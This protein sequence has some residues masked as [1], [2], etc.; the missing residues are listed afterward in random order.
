MRASARARSGAGPKAPPIP[1]NRSRHMGLKVLQQ[2]DGASISAAELESVVD[3]VAGHINGAEEGFKLG[4]WPALRPADVPN[5]VAL[6]ALALRRSS[7]T[8]SP[9]VSDGMR[10][11]WASLRAKLT[12]ELGKLDPDDDQRMTISAVQPLA[13]AV[14]R[15]HTFR[16]QSA[17]LSEAAAELEPS[18]APGPGSQQGANRPRPARRSR[19]SLQA[20]ADA[21][22]ETRQ[23]ICFFSTVL[24]VDDD[25]GEEGIVT[26]TNDT[27]LQALGLE[28]EESGVLDA[29][30]RLLLL[31]A[32]C[33]G[34]QDEAARQLFMMADPLARLDCFTDP[35]WLRSQARMLLSS[36]CLS[37]LLASHVVGLC[38]ALDGGPTYGMPGPAA[39][40]QDDEEQ[41]GGAA[42]AAPLFGATGLRLRR[43]G[44][45][46]GAGT[47]LAQWALSLWSDTL[48]TETED[49]SSAME[50]VLA[51]ILPS[52][53][54]PE[55]IREQL[56]RLRRQ[57]GSGQQSDPAIL[58]KF[59]RLCAARL[60]ARQ[61]SGA[62]PSRVQPL[63]ASLRQRGG[64]AA[65]PPLHTAATFELCM[66]L[67]AAA[68]EALSAGGGVAGA[69][70]A[71]A[72]SGPP[73]G[74]RA[75]KGPSSHAALLR[76][77]GSEAEDVAVRALQCGRRAVGDSLFSKVHTCPPATAAQLGRWWAALCAYID[78]LSRGREPDRVPRSAWNGLEGY[79]AVA[80][81]DVCLEG[82]WA[83]LKAQPSASVAA[84]LQAGYLP[85]LSI[86]LR[87]LP[88]G[89]KPLGALLKPTSKDAVWAWWE[90]L[91]FGPVRDTAAVVDSAAELLQRAVRAM[92]PPVGSSEGGADAG[93]A[94]QNLCAA[95]DFAV[96][97]G[98]TTFPGL[99]GGPA[100]AAA[101]PFADGKAGLADGIASRVLRYCGVWVALTATALKLV[102]LRD[103]LQRGEAGNGAAAGG[104]GGGPQHGAAA[105]EEAEAG[106][107]ADEWR[108]LLLEHI[109]DV[110]GAWLGMLAG[111][112]LAG[113]EL[114]AQAAAEVFQPVT[115]I[116]LFAPAELAEAL[117]SPGAAASVA[118]A[119]A[120]AAACGAAP[121]PSGQGLTV[122][123]ALRKVLG[124]EG[125]VPDGGI[126]FGLLEGL[127]ADGTAGRL[128]ELRSSACPLD[129]L[130]SSEVKVEAGPLHQLVKDAAQLVPPSLMERTLAAA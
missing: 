93:T 81:E 45:P 67:A 85:R 96:S 59:C 80:R 63:L 115:A 48:D 89:P 116:V 25:E 104:A 53:D 126:V 2:G 52:E 57:V 13:L 75:R 9:G 51:S 44:S 82:A 17:I 5:V 23:L 10:A 102:R 21:L 123:E 61:R 83:D 120:A 72:A 97:I 56:Q 50:R 94:V 34:W 36:P 130:H 41:E 113:G 71:A 24:N 98:R 110:L 69:A 58:R 37:Y 1:L 90:L 117:S 79:L 64:L 84:A 14:L 100:L 128:E 29:W 22:A 68:S 7:S 105:L 99:L 122:G 77:R 119:A 47:M 31:L 43:R 78:G 125:Y 19:R 39:L 18:P 121:P 103:E 124:P 35:R 118:A 26:R 129:V 86:M 12:S 6:Y 42:A 15:S 40:E 112:M 32:A 88:G 46:E 11:N 74:A 92:P 108:R 95:L 106:G 114:C 27:I 70:G 127:L 20:A 66:R 60:E 54:D 30:S 3:E 62:L 87:S 111:G 107:E 73:S 28:L 76:V 8:L 55:G 65:M 101:S 49:L 109:P 4:V 91:A 16:C 33:E 38:A